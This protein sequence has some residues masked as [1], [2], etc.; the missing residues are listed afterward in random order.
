MSAGRRGYLVKYFKKAFKN[1]GLVVAVDTSRYSPALYDADKAVLIPE[2]FDE[3]SYLKQLVMICEE[4]K[5]NGLI[6]LN[7][8]ELEI[9]AR[10]AS[11]LQ[12]HGVKVVVSNIKA[13]DICF[14]KYKTYQFLVKH[15]L[16]AIPTYVDLNI[17]EDDLKNKKIGFPLIVKPRKGSASVG[18]SMINSIESLR[19]TVGGRNDLVI[20]PF[21]K[22]DEYGVD[23]FT[24][25]KSETLVAVAKKKLAMRSGET[26]KAITVKSKILLADVKKIASNLG[27]VG[28]IDMDFLRYEKQFFLIDINPRFGGGYPTTQAVGGN[29]PGL[30]LDLIRG[31]RL[32]PTTFRYKSGVVMMKQYEIVIKQKSMLCQNA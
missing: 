3:K 21:V 8:K 26:D 4:Y 5:I 11:N 30:I 12:R 24:N 2:F 7:D 18:M 1:E 22:G 27:L 20:Q 15:K 17:V 6:S 29:F 23:L 10:E 9:L 16:S 13:I 14:D 25:E 28:P 19:L 32:K 31:V